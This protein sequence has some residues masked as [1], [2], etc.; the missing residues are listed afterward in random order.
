M[1]G[2]REGGRERKGESSSEKDL[3]NDSG[4]T[5]FPKFNTK[6]PLLCFCSGKNLLSY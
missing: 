3:P 2:L 4:R 6:A 5:L 1:A